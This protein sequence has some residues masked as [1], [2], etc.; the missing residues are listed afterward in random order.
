MK[1]SSTNRSIRV[2]ERQKALARVVL[3]AV[4]G[5]FCP[6]LAAARSGVVWA[7]YLVIAVLYSIWTVVMTRRFSKDRRVGYLLCVTDGAVLA[8]IVVWSSGVTMRA[9]L[10]FLWAVGLATTLVA[11]GTFKRLAQP[12]VRGEK[13]TGSSWDYK[14]NAR[15]TMTSGPAPLER[16]LRV[17]LRILDSTGTRFG[18]VLLRM[19]G[20]E[21][22]S[23][24]HGGEAVRRLLESVGSEGLAMLG[25]D[26][27]VF[28]LPG[29]RMAFVFATDAA[30]D[31]GLSLL[32]GS[33][34][35][36][37]PYDVESIA[38]A[39][40]R[41]ACEQTIDGHPPECVVGWASAPAD[42]MDPDDL[43]Y[44]AE[45]GVLSTAAFRRVGGSRV[46][47]PEADK[48]RAIAG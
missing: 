4:V 13:G 41:K 1:A 43:M 5:L 45:S 31:T 30:G 29:G 27:Q 20:H 36:V 39:L 48:K 44:A 21:E 12:E 8:P 38:M 34:G 40:A 2:D 19:S 42:G 16:A 14:G 32:P 47:V 23:A 6:P 28:V 33:A 17:R 24:Y 18:L 22:M 11:D 7:V 26:A 3:L 25:P 9:V 46:P 10:V 35:R 15:A 37:A